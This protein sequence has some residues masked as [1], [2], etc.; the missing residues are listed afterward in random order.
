MSK[1]ELGNTPPTLPA[2]PQLSLALASTDKVQLTVIRRGIS[3]T[4]GG[5]LANGNKKDDVSFASCS[6]GRFG[7]RNDDPN[8]P[9]AAAVA[10]KAM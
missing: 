10:I 9:M 8:W 5:W 7:V 3:T 4:M 1:I 2:N 6:S